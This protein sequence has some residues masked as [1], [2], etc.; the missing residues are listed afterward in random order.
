MD[1]TIPAAIPDI[2]R[3]F[4]GNASRRKDWVQE[5]ITRDLSNIFDRFCDE[6][7]TITYYINHPDADLFIIAEVYHYSPTFVE[8]QPAWHTI[9]RLA[10]WPAMLLRQKRR[11]PH[12]CGRIPVYY[13]E[14]LLSGDDNKTIAWC[15][16]RGFIDLDKHFLTLVQKGNQSI[17]TQ[18]ASTENRPEWLL[19]F[20]QSSYSNV[21]L[22]VA[23]NEFATPD[24]LRLLGRDGDKKVV[25]AA[26]QHKNFP[27]DAAQ[28]LSE[29]TTSAFID[30]LDNLNSAKWQDLLDFFSN[31][32]L[33]EEI[34]EILSERDDPTIVFACAQHPNAPHNVLE[35]SLSHPENWVKSAAAMNPGTPV[36][37]LRKLA[38]I[39]DFDVNFALASN[40][41]LPED[42]QIQ[43][44]RHPERTI[45]LHLAD[46]HLSVPVWEIVASF[47]GP[48]KIKKPFEKWLALAINPDSKDKQLRAICSPINN[49]ASDGE[50]LSTAITSAIALHPN[51][52]NERLAEYRYYLPWVDSKN[53]GIQLKILE[54][55][56]LAKPEPYD[57]WQI[58]TKHIANKPAHV[59]NFLA[60]RDSVA[61]NRL[62][63][64]HPRVN[65]TL[66]FPLMFSKD[67]HTL[68][69]LAERTEMP[70]FYY[71]VLWAHSGETV[72]KILRINPDAAKR[73]ASFTTTN[74]SKTTT[75][76]S[77][78]SKVTATKKSD[79]TSGNKQQRLKI[80]EESSD[81]NELTILARDKVADVRREV[82]YRREIFSWPD[83]WKPLAH[84]DA[85][86][87]RKSLAYNPE[88]TWEAI[89]ILS[90]DSDPDVLISLLKNLAKFPKEATL[91]IE[92]KLLAAGD[93][94]VPHVA[95]W[96]RDP[97]LMLKLVT[98]HP[99]EVA[100]NKEITI[101]AVQAILR[102]GQINTNHYLKIAENF[103]NH[104]KIKN[105]TLLFKSVIAVIFNLV[106][107]GADTAVSMYKDI[108]P[109][110]DDSELAAFSLRANHFIKRL[111]SHSYRFDETTRDLSQIIYI[112]S[113]HKD[114]ETWINRYAIEE[115]GILSLPNWMERVIIDKF[116]TVP[117][118]LLEKYLSSA[119]ENDRSFLAYIENLPK[120][121]I[122]RLKNDKSEY[123]RSCI[124][125][126]SKKKKA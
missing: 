46:Q 71:E 87:V 98:D 20:A 104:Q 49:H 105:M 42:L 23:R 126:N 69:K 12:A 57:D 6:W 53:R 33:P 93:Q 40:P 91:L 70:R 35:K 96:T 54:G 111:N 90:N 58:T 67:L 41:A 68:K 109:N 47:P 56:R 3:I 75:S 30:K 88:I 38:N 123:V 114:F 83:C 36:T 66:I 19:H 61:E 17:D 84:D 37:A 99:Q 51:V 86:N 18:L 85:P 81:V 101:D 112:A 2:A 32:D 10:D 95:R 24:A 63:L 64:Y 14:T 73:R 21:R 55:Q 89:E 65:R 74:S 59:A 15:L 26:V 9:Q 102:K 125:V 22:R 100:N 77:S 113:K 28:E 94:V 62:S 119:D 76:K 25:Q 107:K 106:T 13:V 120:E 52:P 60:Q 44:A 118:P 82:A 48:E 79:G 5:D 92:E 43:L 108:F 97:D 116:K 29:R 103:S 80:A 8:S 34:L 78:F 124:A 39:D 1:K 16:E 4:E 110:A 50:T 72:R 121:A 117:P 27:A 31:Q 122:E 7:E 115:H 11:L 45:R